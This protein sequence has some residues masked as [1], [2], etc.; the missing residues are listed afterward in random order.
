M[1]NLF[2]HLALFVF[3]TKL[4]LRKYS[5]FVKLQC[6]E[7]YFFIYENLNENCLQNMQKLIVFSREAGK[8][9]DDKRNLRKREKEF[10]TRVKTR[11]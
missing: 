4:L 1:K 11:L 9:E 10:V 5:K 8:K 2:H 7:V 6:N 3:Y